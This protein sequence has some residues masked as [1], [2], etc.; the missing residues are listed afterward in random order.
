MPFFKGTGPEASFRSFE[1]DAGGFYLAWVDAGQPKKISLRAQHIGP[2]GQALW[3]S[4]GIEVSPH[5]LSA[6]D[7]SG[8]ADGR[9]GVTLY[10]DESDGVHAQRFRTDGSRMRDG[11]SVR[12]SSVTAIQPDAVA[13]AAGGTLLVWRETLAGGRSVLQA[14][15]I[16]IDG[17][18]VWP[19]GGI[20]VSLLASNQTNPRIIYDNMSGMIIAWRD[21]KSQASELRAQRMDF[22]GNRLWGPTGLKITAPLGEDEFPRMSPLGTGEVVF[23]WNGPLGTDQSNFSAESR[24]RSRSQMGDDDFGLQYSCAVQS[25]ESGCFG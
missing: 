18:R 22:L 16:D 4:G 17:H 2:D 15:R 6:R 19:V 8:L 24:T 21:Q 9:G 25:M 13:D 1:D 10:W 7:W 12:M 5:L 3:D 11:D 20:R 23:A 14:Q